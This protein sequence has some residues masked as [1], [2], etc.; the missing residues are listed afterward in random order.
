MIRKLGIYA[1]VAVVFL[2]IGAYLNHR[3]NPRIETKTIETER[4]VIK[5]DVVTVIKEVV[6][7]DGTKETTTE[8]VDHTRER[9][10]SRAE[11]TVIVN[12]TPPKWHLSALA[13]VP[14]SGPYAPVYG[15]QIE[16]RLAGPLF[17]GINAK[18][19]REVGLV[20][21]YEF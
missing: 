5:R 17:V 12:I 9:K 18:T 21:G 14:I 19:N 16:K 15:L 2:G 10:E 3:L 8:T 11:A 4:E 7:P 13:A 1:I 20:V 6:R